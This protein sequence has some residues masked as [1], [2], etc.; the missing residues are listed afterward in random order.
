MNNKWYKQLLLSYFPVFLIAISSILFISFLLVS[1]VSKKEAEKANAI[2]SRYVVNSVEASLRDIEQTLLKELA[3]N[4]NVREFF[5]AQ[6]GQ[7]PRLVQYMLSGDAKNLMTN[8]Y[9]IHSLYFY[10]FSDGLV[11]THGSAEPLERFADKAFIEQERAASPR[12][13]WSSPRMLNGFAIDSEESV[14]TMSKR[15]LLPF[16]NQGLVVINVRVDTLLQAVDDWV[17]G[18]LSFMDIRDQETIIY[19]GSRFGGG[20]AEANSKVMSEIHSDY[21]G[22]TFTSGIKAGQLFGWVSVVSYVWIVLGIAILLLCIIYL[23]YITKRNYKPLELIVKRLQDYQNRNLLPGKSDKDEFSFIDKALEGLIDQTSKFE[24]Q[25][26][27]DLLVHRRQLY[28]ELVSGDKK[29]TEQEWRARTA[30]LH[31]PSAYKHL[32][33]AVA[34]IDDY[35]EFLEQYSERDQQL[36][37]FVLT[38]VIHEFA[39]EESLSIWTEWINSERLGLIVMMQDEPMLEPL[40]RL[41]EAF[42]TWV[43]S[44]LKFSISIGMGQAVEDLSGLRV[45]YLQALF[46]LE[47]KLTMGGNRAITY[48]GPV[49]GTWRGAYQYYQQVPLLLQYFRMANPRWSEVLRDL[50]DH[51]HKDLMDDKEIRSL[52]DYMHHMLNRELEELPE[53]VGRAWD[54]GREELRLQMR[55]A[56][57][58]EDLFGVL[59]LRLNELYGQYMAV[60]DSRSQTVMLEEMKAYIEANYSNPDLSLN[61]LSEKFEINPKYAS[62]LFKERFGMKFV[63]FLVQL[64]M[65]EAKRLLL[66]TDSSIQEIAYKVGYTHGI[67]FGRSFKKVI[68]ATPGDYR[69]LM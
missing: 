40:A 22:W 57:S 61:H 69:K 55:R 62:Q 35:P 21:L 15:A 47:H 32:V 53:E 58:V 24:K 20:R 46:P 41:N 7:D 1:E 28:H 59:E 43:E 36:L 11:L 66:E 10:R 54:R 63:D 31:L 51:I 6:S 34:E 8:H 9:L 67:S 26:Q 13:K 38:N 18:Q 17:D 37:K 4:P 23:V 68:G 29:I 64:R 2:S 45:S 16:G 56:G 42:R 50:F 60:R 5:I 39:Q 30:R 48:S 12:M 25:F 49:E 27:E 52:M 19:P 3:T 14:I 65:E 33:A 44:N